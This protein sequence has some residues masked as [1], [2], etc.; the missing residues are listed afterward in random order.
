MKKSI[1]AIL[2]MSVMAAACGS[3]DSTQV[4]A[5]AAPPAA[6]PEAPAP[7][8]AP[9]AARI[10]DSAPV[11]HTASREPRARVSPRPAPQAARTEAVNAAPAPAA[12]AADIPEYRE[13][14]LPAGTNLS[15]ELKSAIGSDVSEVEDTVRATLRESIRMDGHSVLPAGTEIVGTVTGAERAGRV[16]GRARIAF[17]FTS[18]RHDGE[19]LALRTQPIEQL[20]EATK[21]EDATKIGVG[22]G[23]GA[24]IGGLLGGK[25]G[26]A[27]GAAIGGAA[28]T[29][30]VMATRGKEVRLEPGTE[31][32]ATLSAPL[33]VRVRL[34]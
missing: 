11:A 2:M 13:F 4:S 23:A 5:E 21:G 15:L 6:A 34:Q 1:F 7:P 33:A 18:L 9:A 28:G 29:G 31:V 10:V 3:G 24:V 14:T 25:G 26:A 8:A 32:T 30:A 27:K 19:R 12:R 16:K 20:A 17:Q 22:A